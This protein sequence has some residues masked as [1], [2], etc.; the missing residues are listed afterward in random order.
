MRDNYAKVSYTLKISAHHGESG[1]VYGLTFVTE[2]ER[3]GQEYEE[4]TVMQE[5]IRIK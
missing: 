1:N 3:R 4:T 5:R 2:R